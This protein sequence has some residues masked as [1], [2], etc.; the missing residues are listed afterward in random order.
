MY[1]E[2]PFHGSA[3]RA[4]SAVA[5]LLIRLLLLIII[6]TIIVIIFGSTS[7]LGVFILS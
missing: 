7:F 3:S 5:E 6:I 2:W 1:L 4:M